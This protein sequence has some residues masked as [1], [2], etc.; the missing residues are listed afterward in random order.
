[1]GDEAGF[2]AALGRNP[3]DG[4]VRGAYADW[5]RERGRDGEADALA[6][7]WRGELNAEPAGDGWGEGVDGWEEGVDPHD[8][9]Q[10]VT[11]YTADPVGLRTGDRVR[12]L[13]VDIGGGGVA[14]LARGRVTMPNR[15]CSDGPFAVV[16]SDETGEGDRGR[17]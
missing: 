13:L 8:A 10:W 12:G 9:V 17:D 2:L 11:A 3:L 6:A 14:Y 7:T 5:L 15:V 16:Q 4:V 1:M